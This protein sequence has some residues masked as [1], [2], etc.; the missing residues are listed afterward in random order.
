M[1]NKRRFKVQVNAP[2]SSQK[3]KQ[4]N[5]SYGGASIQTQQQSVS[6][7]HGKLKKRNMQDPLNTSKESHRSSN[8]HKQ[9]ASQ[10]VVQGNMYE[11]QKADQ[12]KVNIHSSFLNIS[13]EAIQ[14]QQYASQPAQNFGTGSLAN[15]YKHQAQNRITKDGMFQQQHG[16]ATTQ[17]NTRM[18]TTLSPHPL[19]TG[20]TPGSTANSPTNIIG[21]TSQ[22]SDPSPGSLFPAGTIQ[23]SRTPVSM[24][25]LCN[26]QSPSKERQK[27]IQKRQSRNASKRRGSEYKNSVGQ[28]K[29]MLNPSGSRANPGDHAFKGDMHT[30]TQVHYDKVKTTGPKVSV[31]HNAAQKKQ[32]QSNL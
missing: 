18:M 11:F 23:S 27:S 26:H 25:Q 24:Q 30:I 16:I 5:Q 17:G 12:A 1:K 28:T 21:I 13:E 31:R 20:R 6:N 3:Q 22:F 29:G 19:N 10:R 7:E 14:D 32:P 8:Q 2:P 4:L 9:A 15:R